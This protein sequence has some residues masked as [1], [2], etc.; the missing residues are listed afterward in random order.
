MSEQEFMDVENFACPGAGACGGQFTA[1][2]MSTIME[3]IGISPVGFN[4][5][6]A[7]S[8]EKDQV[9][10]E[11]AKLVMAML[12]AD[13]RPS[14]IYTPNASGNPI[15]SVAATGRSTNAVLH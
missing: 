15:T 8:E 6:P 3:F 12:R 1:N 11:T 2:T 7:M 9:A 10:F 5:V 13:L 4:S 14:Q